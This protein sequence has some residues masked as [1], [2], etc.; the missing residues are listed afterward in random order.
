MANL[1]YTKSYGGYCWNPWRSAGLTIKKVI[2]MVCGAC[3]ALH[4]LVHGAVFVAAIVG[5]IFYV[6]AS[7]LR[8]EA[9]NANDN[10]RT[11]GT[12]GE[13]FVI[14]VLDGM[15]PPSAY[16]A[17]NVLIPNI[18]SKTGT[19]E[20]DI[21]VI[22]KHKVWCVEVKNYTG[23]VM[24]KEKKG[25]WFVAR[26]SG[27][28]L[29][30]DPCRQG[31]S[32]KLALESYLRTKGVQVDVGVL[33]IFPNADVE[34]QGVGFKRIPICRTPGELVHHMAKETKSVGFNQRKV[35]HSLDNILGGN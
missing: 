28:S 3:I 33:V 35:I 7:S 19:T 11:K 26:A 29:M 1:K 27:L 9:N 20:I 18:G 2:L 8:P 13:H 30:R 5:A 34:V 14:D 12:D 21:L 31:F 24:A 23:T 15:L 17:N 4:F 25:Q 10:P 22:N 16:I 6:G 32:Q